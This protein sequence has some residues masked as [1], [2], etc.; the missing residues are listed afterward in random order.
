MA[1]KYDEHPLSKLSDEELDQILAHYDSNYSAKNKEN[2]K[3]RIHVKKKEPIVLAAFSKRKLLIVAVLILFFLPVGTYVAAKLW[4]ITVEKQDYRLTTKIDKPKNQQPDTG[5]YRLVADYVPKYFTVHDSMQGLSFYEEID[6]SGEEEEVIEAVSNERAI[7]FTL[8]ELD[9]KDTITDDY[10][11]D[12]KEIPLKDSSA[13]MVE[14]ID[15]LQGKQATI[16]RKFFEKQNKFVELNCFGDISEKELVK[17]LN[18]LYL[19]NVATKEEATFVTDYMSSDDFAEKIE[20]ISEGLEP[21]ML[22]VNNKNELVQLNEPINTI[23]IYGTPIEE[24]TVTKVTL[25]DTI[26][27][28]PLSIL[29]EKIKAGSNDDDSF[30]PEWN[31]KGKLKPIIATE[32]LRGDGKHTL[33]K[34]LREFE[35]QPKY[36]EV[37]FQVKNISEKTIDYGTHIEVTRFVRQGS[38]FTDLPIEKT[39]VRKI[40][41]DPFNPYRDLNTPAYPLPTT[42]GKFVDDIFEEEVETNPI[43]PGETGTFTA[44]YILA[45]ED[46]SNLFFNL[47]SY[48]PG[49]RYVQLTQ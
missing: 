32:Y 42:V 28:K 4:E 16:V 37:E 47:N 13:Y 1:K 20:Q 9:K 26:A 15:D 39:L 3:H 7:S 35:I 10:V 12:S 21:T 27:P 38:S 43:E 11:K 25:S 40:L 18:N 23:D 44:S 46:Y 31:K 48:I 24:V 22:D 36:L 17:I 41:S 29:N 5:N 8:Y 45:Y 33:S 19:K 14:K 2:I 6:L 34:E 49:N 30:G